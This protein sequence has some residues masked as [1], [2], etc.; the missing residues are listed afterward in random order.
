MDDMGEPGGIL[1]RLKEI[2]AELGGVGLCMVELTMHDVG[3]SQLD[4]VMER[5][6]AHGTIYREGGVMR[7]VLH[8][9]LTITVT[10]YLGQSQ[11]GQNESSK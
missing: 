2:Q 6:G 5:I 10:M 3:L 11:A 7:V 9:Q 4:G 1:D 8:P